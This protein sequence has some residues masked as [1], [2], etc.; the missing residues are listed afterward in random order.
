MPATARVSVL[1]ASVTVKVFSKTSREK[2]LSDAWSIIASPSSAKVSDSS[3]MS[4]STASG[5]MRAAM[6]RRSAS[7][8][9]ASK[10]STFTIIWPDGL[11]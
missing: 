11:P 1:S 8:Q 5:A 7:G 2:A 6:R 3:A 10:A 9:R 4:G